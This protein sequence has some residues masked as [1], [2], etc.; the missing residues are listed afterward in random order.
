MHARAII[1]AFIL[2]LAC[3]AQAR[4]IV[5]VGD[6]IIS[7]PLASRG[8]RSVA[9]QLQRK[10]REDSVTVWARG[11]WSVSVP[12][13]WRPDPQAVADMAGDLYVVMLGRNDIGALTAPAVFAAA[14]ASWIDTV[15]NCGLAG[16]CSVVAV[17]PLVLPA[18]DS[19]PDE[20]AIRQAIR[21]VCA[22]R[23]W[24]S[25]IEGADLV[26][27]DARLYADDVHLNDAGLRVLS[28]ALARRLAQ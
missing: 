24:C 18:G 21:D 10:L 19:T 5:L 13:Y 16:E 6:S 3:Q 14:Y 23:P 25:L 15:H 7:T 2:A 26:P 1:A 11:G 28:A 8:T 17:T 4:H 12:G 20:P 27:A 9:Y 22:A